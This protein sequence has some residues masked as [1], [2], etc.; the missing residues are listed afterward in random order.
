VQRI[1]TAGNFGTRDGLKYGLKTQ[2]DGIADKADLAMYRSKEEGRNASNFYT[3]EM[4]SNKTA[5]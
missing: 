2:R 4:A 3:A 5:L 1:L